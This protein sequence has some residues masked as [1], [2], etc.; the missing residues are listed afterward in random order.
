MKTQWT[1]N[2]NLITLRSSSLKGQSVSHGNIARHYLP[3]IK[4]IRQVIVVDYLIMIAVHNKI[5][6]LHFGYVGGNA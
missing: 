1:N 2:H 4:G 3:L 5:A 6:A